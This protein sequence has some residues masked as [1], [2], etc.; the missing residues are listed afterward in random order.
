MNQLHREAEALAGEAERAA[1]DGHAQRARE[2]LSRAADL[3]L[4]AL[5]DLP[6]GQERTR[7]VIAV[8]A[9]AMLYKAHRFDE[10][11]MAVFRL[12][13]AGTV[14]KWAAAEL[15]ELLEVIS[16]ERLL[17]ARLGRR[18]SGASLKTKGGDDE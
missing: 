12:L 8:S 13:G 6:E 2:L 9:A 5:E 18:Y 16:D 11:E 4:R 10:A 1:K 15:R 3:E 7:S 14:N 17:T